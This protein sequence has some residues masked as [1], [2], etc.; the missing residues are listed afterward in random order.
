MLLHRVSWIERERKGVR[1]PV[2]APQEDAM[3]QP[4]KEEGG[5]VSQEMQVA[6][7]SRKDSSSVETP[8]RRKSC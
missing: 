8:K 3:L 2:R 6:S 1:I 4:L 5:T 7:Q